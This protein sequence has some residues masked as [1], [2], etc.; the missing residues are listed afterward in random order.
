MSKAWMCANNYGATEIVFEIQSGGLSRTS[1]LQIRSRITDISIYIQKEQ[2]SWT[3][4]IIMTAT[5]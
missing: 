3:T 5:S 2:R 1:N 4:W